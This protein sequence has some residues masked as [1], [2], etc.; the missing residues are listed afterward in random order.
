MQFLSFIIHC[1]ISFPAVCHFLRLYL[2]SFIKLK[3]TLLQFMTS[4]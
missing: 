4:I 3:L 1:F 2:S